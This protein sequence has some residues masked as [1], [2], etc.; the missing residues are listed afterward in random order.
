[1]QPH[2]ERVVVEKK[3][4]DDKREKLGSFIGGN[5]FL[6]LPTEERDRLQQQAIVMTTYSDILGQRIAAFGNDP[7]KVQDHHDHN[8]DNDANGWPSAAPGLDIAAPE[9]A[10]ADAVVVSVKTGNITIDGVAYTAGNEEVGP[11][12]WRV[13]RLSDNLETTVTADDSI[14]AVEAAITQDSWA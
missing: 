13:R 8:E 7:S 1:M 10:P 12:T 4:L 5:I 3:E 14:A 2:Q 11:N 6:T 9:P